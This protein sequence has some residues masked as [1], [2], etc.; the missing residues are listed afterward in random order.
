MEIQEK[1]P[2][3]EKEVRAVRRMAA[4]YRSQEQLKDKGELLFHSKSGRFLKT[5]IEVY[6]RAIIGLAEIKDTR[7]PVVL[8][9]G[10]A[11]L[12]EVEVVK[13][14]L[15]LTMCDGKIYRL[16]YL[17]DAEV[18]EYHINRKKHESEE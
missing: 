17:K 1:K 16:R 11:F 5:Y 18:L 8:R 4:F 12:T 6:E 14:T 3:S 9:C 7:K 13:G 15:Y 2:Y 10:L